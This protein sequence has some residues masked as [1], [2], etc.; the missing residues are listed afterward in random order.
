MVDVIEKKASGWWFVDNG[1]NKGWAPAS[2]LESLAG[3]NENEVDRFAPGKFR[4]TEYGRSV[5]IVT[6]PERGF[7]S[8]QKYTLP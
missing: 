6:N 8:H 7:L 5:T 2:Y 3:K 1:G 4:L